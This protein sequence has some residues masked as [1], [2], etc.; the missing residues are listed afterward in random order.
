MADKIRYDAIIIGAGQGGVPLA[1]AMAKEGK[2][3]ALIE[4]KAIGGTCV[5]EGCTP[6]KT[7]IASA[8]VAYL[9]RR[10]SDYGVLTGKVSLDLSVVRK[11]KRDIVELFREGSRKSLLSTRGL[12]LIEG[13]AK[14]IDFRELSV[15]LKGGD[16]VQVQ[17]ERIFIDTGT[18][19]FIPP[20]PG[21][22]EVPFLDSTSIMELD[23]VPEHLLVIGGGYVGLE[24][25]QMFRRF[26][27]EVTI[28]QKGKQLLLQEDK[29]IADEVAQILQEDGITIFLDC[30]PNSVKFMDR[31]EITLEIETADGRGSVSGSHLLVS[32]GRAPN[33]ENLFLKNTGV[34]TDEK[35]FIK[36][37]ER[38]ETSADGIYALG[39][40]NGGPQFTHISY[41][42][43]RILKTNLL[44]NG[45]ADTIDRMIPYTVFIDPQLGLVGLTERE[46]KK[47][48]LDFVV[49]KIPMKKVARALE[50]DETRGLM[51]ALVERNTEKILG[52]AIL[53]IQGGEVMTVLQVAMM[54]G[55][56]YK[57]I[58]EGTFAHP[59]ISESLNNLFMT[60]PE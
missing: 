32:T 42:D 8:R 31:G 54:G 55:L 22:I 11:R 58:R 7:M 48:G 33:T 47:R 30:E 12:D 29:D 20:I 10:A 34:E 25:A 57:A 36:V 21:L 41:D 24:F 60:L 37:N 4:R 3:T 46:A 14:F 52:A 26:G 43:Y 49:A 56:S 39:D 9:A 13:E 27:S 19:P 15:E 1:K 5:N 53:G 16:T 38:L 6:T 45:E 59:L 35:G 17:A 40:V 23:E 44:E 2:R 28:V 51:K 18:K 50:T